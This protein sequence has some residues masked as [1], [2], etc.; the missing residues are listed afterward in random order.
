MNFPAQSVNNP[1]ALIA[2]LAAT[3][4]ASALA[5]LPL[6]DVRNQGIFVWFLV[7]FPPFLTALFFVTL[8]FNRR[9][10]SA[11]AADVQAEQIDATPSAAP[12]GVTDEPPIAKAQA[13]P[14]PGTP[15]SMDK[16][17]A[18]QQ[19]HVHIVQY[20]NELEWRQLS[21]VVRAWADNTLE[22]GPQEQPC[23]LM[24]LKRR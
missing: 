15:P 7:G 3:T 6:L 4:E 9:A 18:V 8:N 11:P 14:S 20:S 1:L 22:L 2:V 23:A 16:A 17:F 21:P 13:T 10:L 5:S 19:G 12:A 24:L